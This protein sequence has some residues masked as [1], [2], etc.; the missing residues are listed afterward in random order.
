VLAVKKGVSKEIKESGKMTDDAIQQATHNLQACKEDGGQ[1]QI[2]A[3]ALPE[4]KQKEEA[5]AASEIKYRIVADNTYDWEYWM[6]PEGHLLYTSPSCKRITGYE[7]DEFM[8]T[9]GLLCE[10]V[11]PEDRALFETHLNKTRQNT[12]IDEFE[13]RIIC[14][15]GNSKWIGHSCQPV[16]SK[17]GVFLGRRVSNRDITSNK[18]ATLKREGMLD[19]LDAVLNSISEGV[20]IFDLQGNLLEMN[21]A[22]L[23]IYGFK[24]VEE[25]RLSLKEFENTFEIFD[26]SDRLLASEASPMARVLRGERF[27]EIELRVRR[28]DTGK[29]WIGSYSGTPVRD[30]TGELFLAV[31]TLRDITGRKKTEAALME[32]HRHIA[33]LAE[34]LDRSFQPFGIGYPDGRLGICN[35]A[36]TQLLGYSREE[37]LVLNWAHDIT[38]PEWLEKEQTMLEEMHLTGR[39]VRY[40]KEYLRKDGSRVPVE[41]LVQ[42]VRD[43]NGRPQYYYSFIT[44]ITERKQ[45]EEFVRKVE[46]EKSAFLDSIPELVWLLDTDLKVVWSNKAVHRQFNILPDQLA[47]RYCYEA[48]HNKKKPCRSCPVVKAIETGEPYTIDDFPSLEKRW[49]LQAYPIK[50]EGGNLSGIVEIVTDITERKRMEETLKQSYRRLELLSET[51]GWLLTSRKPQKVI[52]ELCYKVMAYL[53]CQAFFN[54]LV[55]DDESRL[56]LNAYSGITEETA[57]EIEWLD[58]GVSLFGCSA[59]DGSEIVA[60]DIPDSQ[61][62]RLDLINSFGIKAC[63][64]YPLFSEGRVIG[65]LSFGTRTRGSFTQDELA[66]MRTVADQVSVAMERVRYIK[67]LKSTREDLQKS[68]DEL[69]SHV[70][71]RTFELDEAIAKLQAEIQERHRAEEALRQAEEK[72]RN[73]FE[74]AVEGIYQVTPDGLFL[75][76]NPAFARMTGYDSEEDLISTVRDTTRQMWVQPERRAEYLRQLREH[77]SVQGFEAQF[78]RK[79]KDLIWVSLYARAVHGPDGQVLY[80]EGTM[81]DITERKR[82][83]EALRLASA[84]HR[85]LIETSPDPLVTI[86]PEGK[87]SD[88]NSATESATGYSRDELIGTDFS[89]YFMEP[90]E[91]RR[92]YRLAF[93]K[94]LVRDYPLEIRHRHGSVTPV[95]YNANVY[96]DETGHV[97]GVFAVARDITERKLSE[98]KLYESNEQLRSLTSQLLMAEERERRRIAVELHDHIGQTLAVIKMNLDTLQGSSSDNDLIKSLGPIR[99]LTNEAIQQTRTLMTEL[100][101]PVLYDLGFIEAMQWLAEQIQTR[102]GINV[103][104]RSDQRFREMGQDIRILLFQVIRELLMNIVRHARAGKAI[105]SLRQTGKNIHVMVKDDGIGFDVARIGSTASQNEGFGL[106]SIQERLRHLGGSLEIETRPGWG[107]CIKLTTSLRIKAKRKEREK[108]NGY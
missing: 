72:Y 46:L 64:C 96:R 31:I 44:D 93:E 26:P 59:R 81:E 82:V 16:Y 29:T 23:A 102:Y 55:V 62:S 83:E 48:L 12:N 69:E 88:V 92:G 91:A 40:E 107:T 57:H 94:G 70:T 58:Y 60:E 52:N 105:I 35:A 78:F 74:N 80:T 95:F 17:R 86:D 20:V 38:P 101:P 2:P 104:L 13:F 108:R 39:P 41:L 63:A 97:R 34:L 61:N 9:P 65:T 71:E 14:R 27:S 10:I 49:T 67:D 51:A 7:A 56:K 79:D 90:Q 75:M 45:A 68:Y 37:L 54:Y 19:Q 99:K 6:T 1:I 77:G 18:E 28:K 43:E 42:L 76:A 33:F 24:S 66:L 30:K 47:G 50:D 4:R 73:I 3:A 100:S 85:S 15:D 25:I 89:D 22:A 21:P 36:F 84:Y 106:F 5:L 11:H 8:K 87:I 103:I 53:D 32:S 98:K